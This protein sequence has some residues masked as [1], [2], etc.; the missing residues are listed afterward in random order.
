MAD[1]NLLGK[2]G[3][4]IAR[5]YLVQQGYKV[6]HANWRFK[7]NEID[8]ITEKNNLL[9]VIEVKTRSNDYFES[10]KE[11]VTRTKQKYIITAT[12][13]YIQE[14]AI[15]MEVRFDIVSVLISGNQQ[16]IEHIKDAFQPSL[17]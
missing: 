3:E 12:E 2:K 8:I 15:D 5:Q 1:H 9:V 7:K 6:R 10:P 14:F 17:L 4:E 16:K 13:A 11:A